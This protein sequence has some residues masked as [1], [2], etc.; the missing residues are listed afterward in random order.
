MK[1]SL[2]RALS[3]FVDSIGKKN[4]VLLIVGIL[5]TTAIMAIEPF[6]MA[7]VMGYIEGYYIQ[8][9][10]PLQEFF[11]FLGIWVG[12]ILCSLVASY[13]HRYFLSDRP[14]LTF[15]NQIAYRYIKNAYHMTLG[16]YL[17]KKTGSIYK[18]FDR[19]ASAHFQWIFFLLKDGLKTIFTLVYVLVFLVITSIPMTLL[20]LSM[21]PFMALSGWY[22]YRKTH[23]QQSEADE[24]WTRAFG[25]L[26]DFMNNIQL[27]K[28]LILERN[29]IMKFHT[30][31]DAALEYQKSTSR[32]WAANDMITTVFV[33]ISR[34]LVFGYGVYM[35]T[36]GHMSLANLMLVF[37]LIGMIYYPLGYLFG[38][39]GNLQKWAV[40]LQKFYEEFEHIDQEQ[41]E[42]GQTMQ[43]P[44][45]E[46]VFDA[47]HFGYTPDRTIIRN[48]SFCIA[49]GEKIALVGNTGAGKSTLISLLFRFWDVDTGEIRIDGVDI[50][51]YSK[52]SLR[53]H[54][55]LVAQDN[56]LFNLSIREN[57]LF[58]RP[59]AAEEELIH[60]L[61]E[62]SANFV[63]DLEKGLDTVI[64]ERGLKLSGGEKQRL[65]IARLFLQNPTILVLD[66]A[67]SALDNATEKSIQN[68]LNHLMEGKTSII[69]AHR[70]STIKH[71]DRI[72]M[73]ENGSIIESGSYDELIA[74]NGKFSRL[75][76]PDNLV[77]T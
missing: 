71:V 12:Y 53:Q 22:V 33:M 58:A 73:I 25:H 69:I 50:R 36:Q 49:P 66:E 64:G 62:A 32:W 59:D 51:Q 77:I 57:L 75:A 63:F 74:K 47:V 43:T 68:S 21:V 6:F 11:V 46:I 18:N 34:F 61:S 48:M 8:G 9:I 3:E 54:L 42:D 37:S 5:I 19:G 76:N 70:L 16:A 41:H 44:R 52:K 15:H 17:Q 72:F 20:S 39:I 67:T 40:D 38:A 30:E 29:F 60:A 28:I 14:A 23:S 35:I 31:L 45:G 55:G 26:G 13:I 10:F 56:S 2:L 4:F 65:S 24:L 27:G 7:R 1:D